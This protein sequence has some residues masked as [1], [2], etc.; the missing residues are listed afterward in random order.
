[1]PA[2]ILIG[3]QWGDE[4]KGKITDILAEQMDVVVRYQG[5]N[6]AGHTVVAGKHELKLHL[7]PSGILNKHV[8]PVIAAGVVIDVKV[9]L[10]EIDTLNALGVDTQ[11]LLISDNAHLIM[12]YHLLIDQQRE[13]RLGK[14]QIGTTKRGIGPA[15]ADKVSRIGIRVQDLLDMKIF[16]QKLEQ[17][18]TLKNEILVKIYGLKPL[19]L[20]ELV[21][22]YQHYGERLKPYITNTTLYI[23]DAL[24]KGRKV[25][26]EGAQGTFLDLDHGTYPFV[27]S[28]SPV[29]G[30]ACV[31]AGIGPRRVSKVI[32]V[33]K[34]YV[35]RVGSGPFPTEQKGELGKHLVT[36]GQEYG[37]TT[38]RQR[39]CG[40]F[41]LPLLKYALKVN[42][43]DA[44]VLTKLDVLSGISPLKV[45]V[46]YKYQG[47]TY[48]EFPTNQT[49]FHQVEPVYEELPGWEE[50]IADVRSF[51][52]LPKGAQQFINFI[53]NA[54]KCPF[55][56]ISVGPKRKQTIV[57]S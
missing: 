53:S 2:T 17:A 15:Y 27:T 19:V 40:W 8:V 1:M 31:G 13:V 11:K 10:Q 54:V 21:A 43:L 9:L 52:E 41:D 29:A 20:D 23:N 4:G 49:I 38:G 25:L 39:R 18:L 33:V 37:T 26:F 16:K 55:E 56:I 44:L 48:A 14:A 12:P 46:A 32:G 5:G 47:K 35:T 28:S 24:D 30:G 34:A 7:I 36:V 45:C 3:A 57:I 22:E 42:S 50:S 51:T 6:N